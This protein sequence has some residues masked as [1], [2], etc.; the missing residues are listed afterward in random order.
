MGQILHGSATT[1]H[2]IRAAIPHGW[3][4]HCFRNR[5]GVAA[6][7]LVPF[8]EGLHIL[9]RH[10][11]R[12]MA[13]RHQPA[14]QMVRANAGLNADQAGRQISKAV[15]KLA[16]RNLVLQDDGAALVEADQVKD[17]LADIDA[18]NGNRGHWVWRLC[19]A[20]ALAVPLFRLPPSARGGRGTAGPSHYRAVRRSASVGEIG[21]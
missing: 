16:A 1:T 17:I 19:C 4:L 8:Q 2:A 3:P 7:V 11:P 21:P 20:L 18:D 10:Q 14:A 13:K 15:L 5:L 9:G 12:I 6:I